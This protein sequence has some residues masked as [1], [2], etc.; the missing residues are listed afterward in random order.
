MHKLVSPLNTLLG[1]TQSTATALKGG[2][3]DP[4]SIN[5]LNSTTSQVGSQ[6]HSGGYSIKDIQPPVGVPAGA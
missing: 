6:A 2:A 5:D 1:K 4:K 3:A